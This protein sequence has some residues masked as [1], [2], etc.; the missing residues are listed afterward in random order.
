ML[1]DDDEEE[2][3]MGEEEKEVIRLTSAGSERCCRAL[4]P[5][6]PLDL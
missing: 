5:C 3:E 2:E 1:L 6:F 4:P